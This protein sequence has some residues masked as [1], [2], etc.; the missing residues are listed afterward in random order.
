MAEWDWYLRDGAA[1]SQLGSGLSD[2]VT[3][4]DPPIPVPSRDSLVIGQYV[5]G[6]TTTGPTVATSELDVVSGDIT[7]LKN[8]AVIEGVYLSDGQI[9]LGSY[10]NCIVRD[11]HLRGTTVRGTDTAYILGQGDNLRRAQIID[12]KFEGQG[13]EWC[14]AVRGGNYS[15]KRSEVTNNSDGFAL[16]LAGGSGTN[17]DLG[18]LTEIDQCWI[19]NGAFNEWEQELG[20]DGSGYMPYAGRTNLAAVTFTGT[21]QATS[22]SRTITVTNAAFLNRD[23][24]RTLVIQGAGPSGG[25]L[26]ATI[27]QVISGTQVQIA[28][29]AQTTVNNGTATMNQRWWGLYTH[30]DGIQFHRSKHVRIRGNMIGGVRVPG[31]HNVYPSQKAA[32]LS[33]DDM[34]NCGLLVKQEVG[35]NYPERIEDVI[36]EDNFFQGGTTSY[37]IV[38][39]NSNLFPTLY[40]RRNKFFRSTW[41]AQTYMLNGQGPYEDGWIGHHTDNTFMDNGAAVPI[42]RGF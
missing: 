17:T 5:P 20:Q 29:N 4:V 25:V 40:F 8:G 1:L 30:S 13:N 28:V 24:N 32:I 38:N 10:S 39:G 31:E 41:G 14:N 33:G 22:G 3:P 7:A 36:I 9:K 18:Y 21:V 35:A 26:T 2:P 27:T 6:A 34:Y 15:V 12:V 19:H 37:N 42:S 23:T 16:T 11:A